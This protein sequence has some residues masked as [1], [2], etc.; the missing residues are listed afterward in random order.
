MRATPSTSPFATLPAST[1][2]SAVARHLD[3]AA[4]DRLAR[5]RRL[6]AHVDHARAALASKCVERGD[7]VA[8]FEPR[9]IR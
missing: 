9:F 3:P 1:E 5:G 4:R 8:R 6:L 2:A 7:R